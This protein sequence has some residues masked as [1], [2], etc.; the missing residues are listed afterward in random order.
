MIVCMF[1]NVNK[2][3][4]LIIWT[5]HAMIN[6]WYASMA[7]ISISY[8]SP[9]QSRT[10][11][12]GINGNLTS[13]NCASRRTIFFPAWNDSSFHNCINSL[14]RY[15]CLLM[16]SWHGNILEITP[17][18]EKSPDHWWISLIGARNV[19]IG[20]FLVVILNK[21][22]KNIRLASELRCNGAHVTS[23]W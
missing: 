22:F 15:L 12:C 11:L 19:E 6:K 23:L 1:K 14:P 8:N 10:F 7:S 21:L 13:K 17:L 3:Y 4:P 16:T 2:S 20:C 9:R 18:W 5:P